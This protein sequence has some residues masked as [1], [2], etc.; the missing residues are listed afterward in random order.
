MAIDG[1]ARAED[2]WDVLVVGAGPAGS[3]AALAAAERD[4]AVLLIDK[5]QFPR[6]K[7]CGGGL[8][9]ASLRALPDGFVVP[10]LA[11]IDAATFSLDGRRA[12]TRTVERPFLVLVDRTDFD[13]R[14]VEAAVSGGATIAAGVRLRSL[15]Q[16][17]DSVVA[18]TSIGEIRARALVGADGSTSRVADYVG[19]QF[20]QVDLGLELEVRATPEIQ[21][22][23]QRRVGLDFGR[24]PGSYAWVF[25]K[26]E[27][28]TVGV[29]SAVGD[30]NAQRRYLDDV[31]HTQGLADLESRRSGGHKTRC[32]SA[33][34]PLSR[35]RVLLCG[36]AAGLLEPWTREGISFAL[37]SG[38]LAGAAAAELAAGRDG[39]QAVEQR[40]TAAIAQDLM[41]E[42]D[43][44]TMAFEAFARH[45]GTF[46][47]AL[48]RTSAGWRAFERLSRSETTLDRA[49]R[50]RGA[51]RAVR[52]LGGGRA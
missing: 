3:A 25:P 34:S 44:G 24:I 38:R 26:G 8:V 41:P 14:L 7:R 51:Q 11:E 50:H 48:T 46:H 40:Y 4:A 43:A 47:A 49:F 35:G 29:I 30:A 15:R 17:P 22:T 45:P 18:L 31:V 19:A 36:D 5:E 1:P 39:V 23:W 20:R 28:L 10:A 16:D 33:T 42:I 37:R 12:R 6:Y 13:A 32:R 52:L 27:W 2:G 9:G 21:R